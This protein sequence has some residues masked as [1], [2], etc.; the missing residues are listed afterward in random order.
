MA[1][2]LKDLRFNDI[3]ARDARVYFLADEAGIA[4]ANLWLRTADRVY[5]ELAVFPAVTFD[6]LF[7]GV[8]ALR[9]SDYVPKDAAFVVYRGTLSWLSSAAWISAFSRQMCVISRGPT[10]W[11]WPTRRMRSGWVKGKLFTGCMPIWGALWPAWAENA[12]LL[13]TKVLS[14][15]SAPAQQ[16]G[17]SCTT[18]TFA[19]LYTNITGDGFFI[20]LRRICGI[21]VCACVPVAQS[22]R[23]LDSDSKGQRFESSRT[24]NHDN[25]NLFLIGEGFGFVVYLHKMKA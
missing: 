5:I 1:R 25:P 23:A 11:C 20:D 13:P 15:T 3:A 18:A 9:W 19:V 6:E 8:R 12:S 7:E 17:E 16:K 24:P 4:R 22:D 21:L 2:E 10:V 14:D